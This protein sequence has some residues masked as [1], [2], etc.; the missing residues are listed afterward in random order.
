MSKFIELTQLRL[1]ELLNYSPTIGSFTWKLR[2]SRRVKVGDSAGS[3][4]NRG[5]WVIRIDGTL[6]QAHRLA[7]LYMTGDWPTSCLD[8][9]D[10]NP[11]NNSFE[12]LR[13]ATKAE[14]N[15]NKRKRRGCSSKFKGVYLDGRDLKWQAYINV[16]G[17]RRSLGRY[18]TEAEA[19]AAYCN[20]AKDLHG[21]FANDGTESI[22]T[23][24]PTT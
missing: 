7:W 1:K 14:N 10:C 22:Q 20:A 23:H 15:R 18:N 21:E 8:H 16:N 5:Y 11:L 4:D 13:A 2:N 17:R 9:I 6:Y 19:H 12:N 24:R 3:L